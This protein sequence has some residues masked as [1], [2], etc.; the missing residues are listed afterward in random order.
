MPSAGAQER[1]RRRQDV[2]GRTCGGPSATHYCMATTTRP[3]LAPRSTRMSSCAT[4]RTG[5]MGAAV[6]TLACRPQRPGAPRAA[7]L[8]PCINDWTA[9][10]RHGGCWD[11][12]GRGR[13]AEAR[14]GLTLSR[15]LGSRGAPYASQ[16]LPP[17]LASEA[18]HHRVPPM[19][20]DLPWYACASPTVVPTTSALCQAALLCFR[21]VFQEVRSERTLTC[22]GPKGHCSTTGQLACL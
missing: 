7:S 9:K 21:E 8:R 11:S 17:H 16:G 22:E 10:A 12:E 20:A 14:R 3:L 18:G 4:P 13:H 5:E 6:R 2:L 19:P 1:P 15:P